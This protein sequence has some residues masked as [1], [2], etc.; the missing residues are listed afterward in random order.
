MSGVERIQGG[1]RAAA[2]MSSQSEIDLRDTLA[3]PFAPRRQPAHRFEMTQA[4]ARRPQLQY[5]THTF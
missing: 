2:A 1:S 4:L 3:Q 5:A